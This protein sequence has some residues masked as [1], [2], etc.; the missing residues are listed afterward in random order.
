MSTGERMF[1]H[2]YLEASETILLVMGVTSCW[3]PI[4]GELKATMFTLRSAR[5][6]WF[7]RG[8]MGAMQM[9]HAHRIHP[10]ELMSPDLISEAVLVGCVLVVVVVLLYLLD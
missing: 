9:R 5:L 6:E 2:R 1:H 4:R 7:S 3:W 10:E 8:L